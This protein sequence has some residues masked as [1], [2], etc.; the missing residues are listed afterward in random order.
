M[1]LTW[2][3]CLLLVPLEYLIARWSAVVLERHYGDRLEMAAVAA[4]GACVLLPLLLSARLGGA[5]LPMRLLL[6][7]SLLGGLLGSGRQRRTS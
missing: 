1:I 7:L 3:V 2:I 6:F 4:L 5:E